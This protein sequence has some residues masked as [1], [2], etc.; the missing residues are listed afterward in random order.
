M[1]LDT[2]DC[3]SFIEA[4]T[5]ALAAAITFFDLPTDNPDDAQAMLDAFD[6]KEF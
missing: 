1:L 5:L 4:E 3:K 6:L 2:V